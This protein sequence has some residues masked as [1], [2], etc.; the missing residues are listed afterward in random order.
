MIKNRWL[1]KL[2]L[3]DI[4]RRVLKDN[5]YNEDKETVDHDVGG[6]CRDENLDGSGIENNCV[7]FEDVEE[8][9]EEDR[10]IIEGINCII[11]EV[12]LTSLLVL[13]DR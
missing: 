12:Y 10:D 8:L 2:S 7:F 1:A 4:K 6:V 9:E 11:D 3:E 13:K 5:I